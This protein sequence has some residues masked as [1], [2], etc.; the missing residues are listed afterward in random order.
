MAKCRIGCGR[1]TDGPSLVCQRCFR[2]NSLEEGEMFDN[3]D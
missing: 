2:R 1:E 3:E